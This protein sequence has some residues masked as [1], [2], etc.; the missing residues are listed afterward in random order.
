MANDPYIGNYTFRFSTEQQRDLMRE[1]W[2]SLFPKITLMTAK[3]MSLESCDTQL[4]EK[5]R[6]E[7]KDL[8]Q[9]KSRHSLENWIGRY[10][11]HYPDALVPIYLLIDPDADAALLNIDFEFKSEIAHDLLC[12]N[13]PRIV[14]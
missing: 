8:L 5:L 11:N 14:K 9:V 3:R 13:S 2:N 12:S 1:Y 4:V 7:L 6:T 10:R